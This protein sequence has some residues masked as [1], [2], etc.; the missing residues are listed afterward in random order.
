MIQAWDGPFDP[1]GIRGVPRPSN[2]ESE[3]E[4]IQRFLSNERVTPAKILE[5]HFVKTT[6]R[7]GTRG[8]PVVTTRPSWDSAERVFAKG[9]GRINELALRVQERVSN[10]VHG[11]DREADS[12]EIIDAL[13]RARSPL[14]DSRLPRP[15]PGG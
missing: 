6:E 9:W 5:P 13:S 1:E 12:C 4:G 7:A 2:P 8:T 10:G 14:R 11:M 15:P 3:L